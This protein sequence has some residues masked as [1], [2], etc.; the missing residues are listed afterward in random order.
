MTKKE[1]EQACEIEKLKKELKQKDSKIKD[2]ESQ[3][4]IIEQIEDTERAIR[5]LQQGKQSKGM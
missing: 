3:K 1:Y 4:N 2:L 5:R